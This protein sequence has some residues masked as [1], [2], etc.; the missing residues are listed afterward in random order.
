MCIRDRSKTTQASG[1]F[2]GQ[3]LYVNGSVVGAKTLTAAGIGAATAG[4]THK[5]A[6]ASSAG[7]AANSAVKLQTARG[8]T[9]LLYTSRWA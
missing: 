2:T 8:V 1:F 6:G 5:Y 9:C 7:G 3:V 4:H